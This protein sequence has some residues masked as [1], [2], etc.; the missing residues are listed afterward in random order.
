MLVLEL[1]LLGFV[2]RRWTRWKRLGNALMIGAVLLLGVMSTPMLPQ[3]LMRGLENRYPPFTQIDDN[4]DR[5]ACRQNAS[6]C[7]RRGDARDERQRFGPTAEWH[8][9]NPGFKAIACQHAMCVGCE[10]T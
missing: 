5:G 7:H 3:A 9:L 6:P 8:L 10:T 2:L 1:A 4:I